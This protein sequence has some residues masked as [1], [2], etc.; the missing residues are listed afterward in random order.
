MFDGQFLDMEFHLV[1]RK[2]VG[3]ADDHLMF[4]FL[5]LY[6]TNIDLH[7]MYLTIQLKDNIFCSNE[8]NIRDEEINSL[9]V[10]A[11]IRSTLTRKHRKRYVKTIH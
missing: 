3:V 4:D 6:K 2:Y 1:I 11:S 10:L 7:G 5:S 8:G 9:Y